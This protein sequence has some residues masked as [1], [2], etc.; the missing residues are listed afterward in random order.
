M[1]ASNRF[2]TG[3]MRRMVSSWIEREPPRSFPWTPLAKPLAE[4]TLAL[5]SS[6]GIAL[7][8]DRPFDQEGERRD[9]WWGDP[10]Y[11]VIPRHTTTADI[12]VYHL[13]INPALAE[14]DLNCLLPIERL[15]ELV[16]Q[17]TVGSSAES[18]YSFM[19]YILEPDVLLGETTPAMIGHMSREGVDAALL[20]PA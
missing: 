13:H 16:R 19:G 4:S 1:K 8:S 12:R 3:V 5:V 15:D 2:V 18:H 14:T 6:G 9:P 20:I 10:S 11:R 17:G 7:K